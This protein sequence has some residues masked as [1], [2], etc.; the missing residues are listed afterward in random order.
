M[1]VTAEFRA[2][3]LLVGVRRHYGQNC[4]VSS[5]NHDAFL[6]F[7]MRVQIKIVFWLEI[8]LYIHSFILFFFLISHQ[9]RSLFVL[10]I[11]IISLI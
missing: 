7:L 2:W 11:I 3:I 1:D 8:N 10:S 6:F 9:I 5:I 4:Q